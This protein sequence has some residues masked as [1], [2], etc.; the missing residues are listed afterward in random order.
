MA[1]DKNNLEDF[2]KRRINDFD[3]PNDGW[4]LPDED[5]WSQ[6]KIHFPN[7]PQKKR[8]DRKL[9]FIVLFLLIL[10]MITGY[11]FYLQNELVKKSNEFDL[12]K[13][14]IKNKNNTITILEK[15]IAKVQEDLIQEKINTQ[16]ATS[17]LTQSQQ[18]NTKTIFN[19][20]KNSQV[21]KNENQKWI[22]ELMKTPSDLA[23][24]RE[25]KSLSPKEV[26]ASFN[27]SEDTSR[28]STVSTVASITSLNYPIPNELSLLKLEVLP[29]INLSIAMPYRERSEIGIDFIHRNF[30][31]PLEY[32]F[33][34]LE[35]EDYGKKDWSFPI[36]TRGFQVRLSFEF[37]SNLWLTSGWRR[38]RGG[39]DKIFSDKLIYDKSSEYINDKGETVNEFDI[40]TQSSFS[41]SGSTINFEI[42]DGTS[43]N[44]GDFILTDW[45][46]AQEYTFTQI[47]LGIN[48]FIGKNKLKWNLQGGIGWNRVTFSEYFEKTQLSYDNEFLPIKNDGKTKRNE[49]KT[50]F[51]NIYGGVGFDYAL[52]KYWMIRSAF[53]F[54]K[55]FLQKDPILDSNSISK[56]FN[57][58]LSHRF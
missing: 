58:G 41:D 45:N 35:K 44:N 51:M 53:I 20:S 16:N 52:N 48:Y 47:P 56:G 24:F 37:F 39:F 22:G 29:V 31:M 30:E 42:P 4:D 23:S 10:G 28:V 34:K 1:D 13:K 11:V 46:Y 7:H 32:D 6:A 27:S 18:T 49:F 54:E 50:R 8:S 36:N 17:S 33:E 9:M 21:L 43:I 26:D 57:L 12:A 2:F 14:E 3:S 55:N 40:T 15:T 5:V 25:A 19:Q 38:T